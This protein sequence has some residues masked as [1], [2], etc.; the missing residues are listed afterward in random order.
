MKK[1]WND[2]IVTQIS[3]AIHVAPNSGK[4]I[5]K[6]RPYHGLVLNDADSV[7]DYIFDDGRILHTKKNSL[8]YL[9]KASSYHVK[10]LQ[11]GSCYAINFDAEI[12]DA[13]FCIMPK[14]VEALKKSFRLAC[15]EWRTHSPTCRT[16]AMRAVY[17][18]IYLMGKEREHSY[19]QSARQNLIAPALEVINRDFLNPD[20]KITGL[21]ALCEM[22][23]V[24]FRKIFIHSFGIS[25]KEYIIQK[26]MEY[27]KQLLA[28]GEFEVSK[29][30]ELCGYS[31]PCHFSR[32]FKKRFGV[33]PKSYS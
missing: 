25:P 8:F 22:S 12:E 2:I 1:D 28:L 27:A 7:K 21:A 33:A 10:E 4:H 13:P 20:L 5:H 15:D 31:E 19:M 18:V 3:I 9:P 24:Y 23:E 14:N 16:A 32:E 6:N 26:R 11:Q 30:A 29:I 17:D